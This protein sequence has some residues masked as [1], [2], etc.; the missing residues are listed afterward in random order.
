MP[1]GFKSGYTRRSYRTSTRNQRTNRSAAVQA[2][3][4]GN[5][6]VAKKLAKPK[7]RTTTKVG[8]NSNAIVTLARQVKQLQL[9][10]KGEFQKNYEVY[11]LPD[12]THFNSTHPLLFALNDMQRGTLHEQEVNSGYD[13]HHARGCPVYIGKLQPVGGTSASSYPFYEQASRFYDYTQQYGQGDNEAYSY[14]KTDNDQTASKVSYCP[15]ANYTKIQTRVHNLNHGE[16]IWFRIDVIRR[17]R[18]RDL[19]FNSVQKKFLPNNL[20]NLSQLCVDD[21]TS[22]NRINRSYYQIIK[23][24]WIKHTNMLSTTPI[25]S[26]KVTTIGMKFKQMKKRPEERLFAG[27]LVTVPQTTGGHDD[28]EELETSF[29]T[30]M[31][32]S[33][34]F[35][36]LVNTSHTGDDTKCK[37]D[38]TRYISWRD[39]QMDVRHEDYNTHH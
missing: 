11:H 1:H 9:A 19:Q 13:D 18:T 34:I 7:P 24:K 36:C 30:Q 22:R 39:T 12:A 23:T 21:M 15:I 2:A 33:D 10:D 4:A 6:A 29:Y 31:D 3:R 37:V 14:W 26:H 16:T 28:P 17:K 8:R 20:V 5:R 25:D 35:W 27:E 32:Q 38:M